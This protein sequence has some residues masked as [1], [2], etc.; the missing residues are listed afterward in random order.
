MEKIKVV[1][2]FSGCGGMD[3]GLEG[4]FNFLGQKYPKLPFKILYAIDNDFYAVSMYNSNFLHR[5]ELKDV[6]DIIPYNLP[7]HHLLIGGFPC[8]SFSISAQNPPRLGYKD[9]RGKLFFE[10]INILKVKQPKFF[11]A[12]NVK[13][14]LS[15]NKKKAFP[16]IISEF[17]KAGYHIKYKLLN[18]SDYGIP[19]KRERIFIIGFRDIDSYLNFEFPTPT[20]KSGKKVKLKLVIDKEADKNEKWFFSK[21]AVDG[22][23]RV[24]EK[25]NKGREQ[26]LEQQCNTISSHLS[27]MSLNSTDPVLKINGKFRRFT[28]RE[29]ANIQSFP[30]NFK[31]ESVS[32]NRQ[33]KAIGNAVP[34]VMMWHIANSLNLLINSKEKNQKKLY[35]EKPKQL[36]LFEFA[37]L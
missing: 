25:M 17:E 2:L 34:P 15:A 33:Y 21:R 29:A 11:I 31:L 20:T 23:M 24:R 28:P 9:E 19:Q 26:D 36:N 8:Q 3:L 12:E 6:K 27:K 5:C 13:G 4:G 22:M 16:M 14:L 35:Y 7:N 10:M 32:E 18:S 30:K 37:N 1:S